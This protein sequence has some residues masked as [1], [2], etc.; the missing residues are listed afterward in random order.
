[1]QLDINDSYVNLFK[2][3]FKDADTDTDYEVVFDNSKK[4]FVLS[5]KD[6]PDA[7][8]PAEDKKEFF[9]S[10]LFKRTSKAALEKITRA[11]KLYETVVKPHLGDP[12][13]V[14][15]VDT[16][17]AEAIEDIALQEIRDDNVVINSEVA[18]AF[19]YVKYEL[20]DKKKK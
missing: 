16:T 9:K 4:L 5:I 17:K 19:K 8:V 18:R 11:F 10:D 15:D 7:E 1:M 14:V 2:A 6:S 13:L 3:A 12:H 20:I